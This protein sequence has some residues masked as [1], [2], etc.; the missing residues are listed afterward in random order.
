MEGQELT[1]YFLRRLIF[2]I[3]LLVLISFLILGYLAVRWFR[4]AGVATA[5]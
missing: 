5:N 2:A 1:M 4:G 3:P